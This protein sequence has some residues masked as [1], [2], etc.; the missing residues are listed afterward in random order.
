MKRLSFFLILLS[1]QTHANPIARYFFRV[2]PIEEAHL[3]FGKPAENIFLSSVKVLVWNIKKTE[4]PTWSSEFKKYSADRDM[5]LAQEAYE[6]PIF[7][8]TLT[9]LSSFQWDLGAS[10]EFRRDRNRATGVMI[11][12]KVEPLATLVE[13]T[14]DKEPV[15]NTPKPTIYAKYPLHNQELL[16]ISVHA[17]NLTNFD[18][19]KRHLAQME[20]VISSHKGPVLWAGDFNTRTK[21]RTNYLMR[22]VEKLKFTPVKFKN[23]DQ[24]MVF[25][26]T[27]NFLDHA[28]LRDL[29]A[30]AAE[31]IVDSRGSDH[32]PLLLE[33][34]P[35]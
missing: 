12:S 32:K 7:Y 30:E 18:T 29:K 17:I 33:V 10:F 20:N 9:E 28:F 27:K 31:V 4:E 11:G 6:S 23:G 2:I 1:F 25:K 14:T 13:H 26:F 22:L 15:V 21:E 16:V 8:S 5:I 24:R 3:I 19:F 34:Y 35:D